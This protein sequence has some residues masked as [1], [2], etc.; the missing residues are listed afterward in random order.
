[1]TVCVFLFMCFFRVLRASVVNTLWEI[2]ESTMQDLLFVAV[3]IAFF[4]LSLGY[5]TF[6]DRIK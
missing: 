6:C 3:T 1:M 4:A 2:E 5:V